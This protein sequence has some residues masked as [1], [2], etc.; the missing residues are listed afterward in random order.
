MRDID[1]ELLL[2]ALKDLTR[3]VK[4]LAIFMPAW[5]STALED[6]IRGANYAI[7]RAEGRIDSTAHEDGE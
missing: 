4:N 7:N 3:V 6:Y 2:E 5:V 1:K